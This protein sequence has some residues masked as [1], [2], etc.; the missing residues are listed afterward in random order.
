[1]L[2]LHTK[3]WCEDWDGIYYWSGT[4]TQGKFCIG[5]WKAMSPWW[6]DVWNEWVKLNCRPKKNSVTLHTLRRWPVWN[7]RIL[8]HNHGIQSTLRSA[9]AN[10]TTRAHMTT[11]RREGFV[12]FR[13]FMKEDGQL[14]SGED[15]Y[16]AVTVCTSVNGTD[17]VVPRSACNTLMR[18]ITALWRNSTNKWLRS[19]AQPRTN[20]H[21]TW[22]P[23]T[24]GESPFN[25]A[26][27]KA[28]SAMVSATE[29]Q[30]PQPR[31]IKLRNTPLQL[32]WKREHAMLSQ[33]A[34][35]R[36]D[37]LRRLTR[38][39]LPVGAKNVHWHNGAQTLCMLCEDGKVETARNLFWECTFAT[40]V[41][42]ELTSPWCRHHNTTITWEEVLRGY[43]VRLAHKHDKMIDQLWPIVQARIIRVVW[44]ER[45]RR[46]FY[47]HSTRR[48]PPF[49][50]NKGME[51]I[52]KR[53]ES[54][55]R[56]CNED[57]REELTNLLEFIR[58]N[59]TAFNDVAPPPRHTD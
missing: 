53:M 42:G 39:A 32:C 43:E 55:L 26:K 30:Q 50:Q 5:D 51:D 37:L 25:S 52:R 33:L 29:P 34:P 22:W 57:E 20:Q 17:H 7:N 27:N 2:R 12:S 54:W 19:D 18:L 28:I 44:F 45:N 59:S 3:E 14:M 38:N 15:L 35:S 9:F 24:G 4:Q 36:R 13:H 8:A 11:I 40:E 21:I 1:M 10:S 31:M 56:R 23:N 46:Y 49:R 16:T 58:N 47:P 41:W 48:T 6:R